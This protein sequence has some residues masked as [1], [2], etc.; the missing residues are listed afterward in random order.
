MEWESF[1]DCAFSRSLPT[2]TFFL[3]LFYLI[4]L[5][6]LLLLLLLL[7][8]L[9]FY[10]FLGGGQRGRGLITMFVDCFSCISFNKLT[11]DACRLAFKGRTSTLIAPDSI[12]CCCF[13]TFS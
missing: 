12:H 4:S 3:V 13:Y 11:L 2:C 8:L 7:L 9:F 5:S 1:S 10:F 6:Y